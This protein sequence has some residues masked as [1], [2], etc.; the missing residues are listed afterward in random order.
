M[1][2][3]WRT[4]H[5]VASMRVQTMCQRV[6]LVLVV[7]T[8]LVVSAGTGWAEQTGSITLRMDTGGFPAAAGTPVSNGVPF[9]IGAL[10]TVDHLQLQTLQGSAIMANYKSLVTWPDGSVKSALVSF[11]PAQQGGAYPNTVL[12]YGPAVSHAA[13]G[14]VQVTQDTS[15]IT[16][17]TD[18]LKLQFSKSRFTVLEQ[19]WTD[20]NG[21]GAFDASEQ[22]LTGP[23]DLSIVDKKTGQTFKA[24]LWTAADGYSPK[25]VEQGPEKVTVLLDGRLKGV[26]GALTSE[27]DPTIVEGKI[28]V[29]VSAGSS[30]VHLQ[31][32]IIDTKYRANDQFTD[33]VMELSGVTLDVPTVMSNGTYAAG[34][35]GATVYQGAVGNPSVLLQDAD[36]T[37]AASFTYNF[38]YSGVGTGSKAP[39]WMDV[40][41]SDRGIM[42]GLRHFWQT[43]PHKLEAAN[44]GMLRIHFV[45]TDSPNT[46]WTVYP[47]VGKTYEAFLDLH[48]GGYTP[49]VL[50]RAEL[51]LARPVLIADPSWYASTLAFGPLSPPSSKTTYWEAKMDQQYNCTVLQ[52]GCSGWA[53]VYGQ[54]NFGD[55]ELGYGTDSAGKTFPNY[56]D[57]HYED[58]HGFFLEF[59]RTGDRKW[60]DHAAEGAR[61]HYDL[62]VM[63]TQSPRYPGFPAGKIHWHGSGEHEGSTIELGHVVPGGLYEYYILT[64]DPR[65]LEVEREQGDWVEAWARSGGG[66][67]APE[68]PSDNP[69]LEEYERPTAWT[70]YTVLK[71]YETTADPK[72]LQAA[73]ILVQNTIDWWKWP[74]DHIVFDSTKPLDLT[75]SPQSQAIFYQRSDWTQ[76][77]GYPLPTLRVDNCSQTSAPLNNYPYQTHAPIAWMSGLLQNALIRYYWTLQQLGGVYNATVSYRGQQVALNIDSP[78]MR[79]MLIQ[80]AKMIADYT[81][82]G[83]PTYPSLYPWLSTI[84]YRYFVYS[85]CPERDPSVGNG[86]QY[87]AYSFAFVS[88]FPQ[89]QVSSRWQANWPQMVKKWRDIALEQYKV[90]VIER[91][92][93]DTSYGGVGDMWSMPYAVKELE[94]LGLLDNLG[95]APT[96]P[97]PSGG[98]TPPPS[99]GGTP[100]PPAATSLPPYRVSVLNSGNPILTSPIVD[101][102]LVAPS[103]ATQVN[104]SPAG[105]GQGTWQQMTP[106]AHGIT[107]SSTAGMKMLYIQFRDSTNAVLASLVKYLLYIPAGFTGDVNLTLNEPDDTFVFSNMADS[108]FG[109]RV[110]VSMGHYD[111][112]Y[113]YTG[114]LKFPVPSLPSGVTATVK[115]AIL[116]VYYTDNS[117]NAAQYLTPY[118]P[119]ADWNEDTVTWNTRPTL[120]STA[121]GAQVLFQNRSTIN[122][123]MSFPLDPA[124]VQRWIQTPTSAHG[125]ALVGSGTPGITSIEIS[126]SEAFYPAQDLRPQL[127]FTLTVSNSDKTPPVISSVQ[128]INIGQTT[129]TIQWATDK[130]ADGAV[131]YGTTTA[132]GQSGLPQTILSTTHAIP[133]TGLTGRTTYH[134][135]VTSRDAFG[136]TATS[137]D[138][139]FTTTGPIPGDLNGDGKVTIADIPLLVSQLLGMSPVTMD[140]ADVNGDGRLTITD[141]QALIAKL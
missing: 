60:F 138:L 87:L 114:L 102:S 122:Q 132:Y 103:T 136:N 109:S 105:F 120:S 133:L 23:A 93:A 130:N 112:G 128:A 77:T 15:T 56:G 58:A 86:G 21:N 48:A 71:A 31:T 131:Q 30:V 44:G 127:V 115:N 22:W 69:G 101:L 124:A 123:W 83:A 29:T 81:Y 32:T 36:A 38:H 39:G 18:V 78:T 90:I 106:E 59:A 6:W 104:I 13:T 8:V 3:Q 79:E 28:W 62:D 34:G 135:Q 118:E 11:V 53:K 99:G 89:N 45:P 126:S 68:L 27:G 117:R 100:P 1:T 46:F 116:N 35:D 111:A 2:G 137:A 125:I 65:A 66:R 47:G 73:S 76:G 91:G 129:A 14:P 43:F 75:K 20:V 16:V 40:S 4:I 50:Q 57:E 107:L 97:P 63:H 42:M 9:P 113:D 119:S 51:M 121:L 80:L 10:A 95:S 7:G 74:Q 140:T 85:V 26:N 49:S 61:H 52:Q 84:G 134:A 55:Y 17:T 54:R 88:E 82:L 19:A 5:G 94:T 92:Y 41:T 12:Q 25:V 64:G 98:G 108:N 96:P 139:T 33:K 110:V 24:S 141:L 37:F 67:I 72:Y 70:L